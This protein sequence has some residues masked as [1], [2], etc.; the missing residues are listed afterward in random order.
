[1]VTHGRARPVPSSA[2]IIDLEL[3]ECR[4]RTTHRCAS[5]RR[6]ERSF[7]DLEARH[8]QRCDLLH[9]NVVANVAK[10]ST[11]GHKSGSSRCAAKWVVSTPNIVSFFFHAPRTRRAWFSAW[12]RP[13]RFIRHRP[14]SHN[15]LQRREAK[16]NSLCV[17]SP[18]RRLRMAVL[19]KISKRGTAHQ[20]EDGG[21]HASRDR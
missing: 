21:Q 9:R 17:D 8:D 3:N 1:M 20:T 10:R 2:G 18:T 19:E 4:N 12:A 5:R 7:D 14:A 6:R 15:S 11:H 13:P 16:R